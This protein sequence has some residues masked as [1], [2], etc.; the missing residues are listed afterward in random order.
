M[1]P[2]PS[3]LVPSFC[4]AAGARAGWGKR[5]E[6]AHTLECASSCT[7]DARDLGHIVEQEVGVAGLSVG[8]GLWQKRLQSWVATVSLSPQSSWANIKLVPGQCPVAQQPYSVGRGGSESISSCSGQRPPTCFPSG[9][10]H[11]EDSSM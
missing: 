4:S 6:G 2:C 1:L 7:R 9:S 5:A 10:L 8:L 3:M 11:K